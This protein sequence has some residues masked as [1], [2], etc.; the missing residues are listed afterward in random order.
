MKTGQTAKV[1]WAGAGLLFIQ[2]FAATKTGPT[3]SCYMTGHLF[4]GAWGWQCHLCVFIVEGQEAWQAINHLHRR[5]LPHGSRLSM[6][7]DRSS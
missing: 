1:S 5:G 4:L 7:S 2:G 3:D 6:G